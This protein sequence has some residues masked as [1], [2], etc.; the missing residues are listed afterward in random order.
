[1][2]CWE[3][4]GAGLLS[5]IKYGTDDEAREAMIQI[6]KIKQS[7]GLLNSNSAG[8]INP[9]NSDRLYPLSKSSL[10]ESVRPPIVN[11]SQKSTE[12]NQIAPSEFSS[13]F[14]QRPTPRP[15]FNVEWYPPNDVALFP[16]PVASPSFPLSFLARAIFRRTKSGLLYGSPVPLFV[17]WFLCPH[18]KRLF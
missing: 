2:A 1:M 17:R 12:N 16:P 11:S 6:I 10:Q 18:I 4:N 9:Q 8:L 3:T 15:E 5:M 14:T 7:L 13:P